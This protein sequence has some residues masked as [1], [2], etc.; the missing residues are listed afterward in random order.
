M[1][2][3]LGT[4][5]VTWPAMG[6]VRVNDRS[7]HGV[8]LWVNQVVWDSVIIAES[9]AAAVT[10]SRWAVAVTFWWATRSAVL[11]AANRLSGEL[12][13]LPVEVIDVCIVVLV[14]MVVDFVLQG[15]DR[16]HVPPCLNDFPGR[17][18]LFSCWTLSSYCRSLDRRSQIDATSGSHSCPWSSERLAAAGSSGQQSGQYHSVDCSLHVTV[19]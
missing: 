16:S 1:T 2:E 11:R 3:L 18:C 8:L 19:S 10:I 13:V 6:I 12:A 4:E 9:I 5:E 17:L 7:T 15:T 14:V